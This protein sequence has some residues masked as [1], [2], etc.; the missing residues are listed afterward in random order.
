MRIEKNVNIDVDID[1]CINSD[2]IRNCFLEDKF[3]NSAR[4]TLE[5]INEC[6]QFFD[7]IP[8]EIIDKFTESQHGIIRRFLE[9]AIKKF[10]K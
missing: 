5:M 2:D 9:K 10:N 1:V 6:T 7:G 8:D 4:N 3:D